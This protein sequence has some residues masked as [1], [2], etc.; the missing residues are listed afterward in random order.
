MFAVSTGPAATDAAFA[1]TFAAD[2]AS[3]LLPISN[4]VNLLFYDHFHLSLSWYAAHILPAALAGFVA[5][6][7]ICIWRASPA[8][9]VDTASSGSRPAPPSRFAPFA[10]AVVAALAVA[11]IA[12]GLLDWPLGVITLSGGLVL[13]AGRAVFEPEPFAGL[14][15]HIAPGLIVFVVALLLLVGIVR[16]AGVLDGLGDALQRLDRQPTFVVIAGAAIIAT[17]LANLMNNWPAALLLSA[18]IATTTGD[19]GRLIAGSLI[20]CTIGA[21]LTMVGSLSTVFW[22]TLARQ[23]GAVYTPGLYIRR[24]ALPTVAALAAACVTAALLLA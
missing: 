4:P 3:L 5:L 14:R 12:A 11:Y 20:G 21:N 19:P 13:L 23:H 16:E 2:G 17:L 10:I 9:V 15:A 22:L 18:T 24:A 8:P 6:A 1:T 7:A